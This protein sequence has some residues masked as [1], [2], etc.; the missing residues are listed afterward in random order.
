M[1]GWWLPLLLIVG[2]LVGI[3]LWVNSFPWTH[4]L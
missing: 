3:A 1:S 4:F 2:L